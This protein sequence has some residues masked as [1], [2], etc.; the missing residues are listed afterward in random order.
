ML[1]NSPDPEAALQLAAL[2]PGDSFLVDVGRRLGLDGSASP[3]EVAEALSERASVTG[4]SVEFDEA[5]AALSEAQVNRLDT[6][7]RN[8]IRGRRFEL[9]RESVRPNNQVYLDRVDEA[10]RRVIV[11]AYDPGRG[12]FS[13]KA[14]QL[15]NTPENQILA[16]INEAVDKYA[17]GLHT[18]AD[19][20]SRPGA[21]GVGET[22][23]GDLFVE[24]PEQVADWVGPARDRLCAHAANPL[25]DVFLVD[26]NGVELCGRAL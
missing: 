13:L 18:I 8:R 25:I 19:V 9:Q 16:A 2:S 24:F 14:F 4:L 10:G 23:D 20:P 5:V 17:P 15:Q 26:A 7:V 6:V 21:L 22:L 12:I 11:D 3:V 1:I